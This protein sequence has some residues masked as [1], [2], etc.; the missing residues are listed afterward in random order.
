M[1]A[2][3]ELKAKTEALLGTRGVPVNTTLPPI[4]EAG[5]LKF[6]SSLDVRRRCMVLNGVCARAHG[7][8]QALVED[9]ISAQ[10][11]KDFCTKDELAVIRAN[12]LTEEQRGQYQTQ[13]EALWEL[14]WVL[15]II[16]AVDHFR[17]C[18]NEF[19]HMLP[20]VGQDVSG[21]LAAPDI[22]DHESLFREADLLYRLHWSV[23]DAQL[24]NQDPPNGL[25]PFVTLLRFQAI[26]WVT[27]SD[28]PWDEVDVST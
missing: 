9:W 5:K 20:K 15:R 25:Q 3:K 27:R 7:A 8:R 24:K 4:E 17:D 14:A 13:V 2:S 19:I 26:N 23:R 18:S 28:V 10:H 11:L 6:A 22:Q 21:F 1:I 12:T 16:P